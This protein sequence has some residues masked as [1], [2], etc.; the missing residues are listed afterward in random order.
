MLIEAF[1]FRNVMIADVW[2]TR[3]WG[4]AV[5][6][7]PPQQATEWTFDALSTLFERMCVNFRRFYITMPELFLNSAYI[8]TTLQEVSSKGMP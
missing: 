4:N 3:V 1:Q 8:S 2:Q 5:V 6:S 7:V